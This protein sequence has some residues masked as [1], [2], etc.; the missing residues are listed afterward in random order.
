MPRSISP[1][2]GSP[3]ARRNARSIQTRTVN[4]DASASILI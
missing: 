1:S 4:P 3:H 2:S